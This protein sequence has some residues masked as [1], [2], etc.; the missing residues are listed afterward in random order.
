[1]L[2]GVD[3]VVHFAAESHVDRSIHDPANF[4]T[5]NVLG[6]RVLLDQS[7]KLGVKR[8]HH[9]STD[10]VFGSLN[11]QE[12]TRFSEDTRYDPRSP[13]SASKPGQIIWFVRIFI[14]SVFLLQSQTVQIITG[15][16]NFRRK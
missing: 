1:M 8:F 12:N 13:Y 9:I 4:I 15:H 5:S 3:T 14:P 7:V 10:E 6:T 16:I 2:K 11:L